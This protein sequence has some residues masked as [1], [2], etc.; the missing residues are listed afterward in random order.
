MGGPGIA[1]PAGISIR[2]GEYGA[3]F[4]KKCQDRN[5]PCVLQP[6]HAQSSTFNRNYLLGS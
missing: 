6:L 2:V 3:K 5:R 1:R 4:H